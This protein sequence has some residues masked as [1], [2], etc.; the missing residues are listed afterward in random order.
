MNVVSPEAVVSRL[1]ARS[2]IV[3]K[4]IWARVS[5]E[6]SVSGIAT[7]T[8]WVFVFRSHSVGSLA[9]WFLFFCSL[10][11]YILSI[12][13]AIK[14]SRWW[15]VVTVSAFILLILLSYVT[16]GCTTDPCPL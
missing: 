6:G 14:Q 12:F 15:F 2:I 13:A 10:S 7:L 4:P 11:S 9:G 5:L 16:G 8:C 1:Q 3:D